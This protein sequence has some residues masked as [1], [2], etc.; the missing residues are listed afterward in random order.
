MF[1]TTIGYTSTWPEGQ[2]AKSFSLYACF[3]FAARFFSAFSIS[4]AAETTD[5]PRYVPH[6]EHAT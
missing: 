4:F 2:G 6:A 1:K 3:A 5:R